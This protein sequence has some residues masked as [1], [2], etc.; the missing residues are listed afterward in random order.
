MPVLARGLLDELFHAL[1]R[2][3]L[4]CFVQRLSI[5]LALMGLNLGISVEISCLQCGKQF[6]KT[7]RELEANPGFGCP[8]GCGEAFSRDDLKLEILQGIEKALDE[9]GRRGGTSDK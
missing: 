1:L 9:L 3:P 6:V 5:I 4:L 8:F 2:V 7:L